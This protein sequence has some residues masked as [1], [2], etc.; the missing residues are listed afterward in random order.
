MSN[1]TGL[2]GP[3]IESKDE[4]DIEYKTLYEQ[5]KNKKVL[6]EEIWQER[7]NPLIPPDGI[8]EEDL[9][10][11][12]YFGNQKQKEDNGKRQDIR[13]VDSRNFRKARKEIVYKEEDFLTVKIVPAKR[14]P[15]KTLEKL[16][17]CIKI[18]KIQ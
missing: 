5:L 11:I 18:K 2:K 10:I 16:K 8:I 1:D 6:T 17:N 13:K 7:V 15:N 14:K 12:Q 4:W 9:E 3:A